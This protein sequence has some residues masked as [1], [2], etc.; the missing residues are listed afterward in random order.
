ME[1]ILPGGVLSVLNHIPDVHIVK[2]SGC[3]CC[4][5]R[6]SEYIDFICGYGPL[7]LG[8]SDPNINTA[9]SKQL[10]Q[11]MLFPSN[12]PLYRKL[13]NVLGELFER[14][15]DAI[16]L[17]T[18]SEAVHAAVR[19]AR[20]HTCK[21]LIVRCGFH[22]WH[23]SFVSP[24]V[25][26]HRYD[27]QLPS[28]TDV[29]GILSTDNN[30][31]TI[32]WDGRDLDYL[33]TLFRNCGSDIA[34]IIID[35]IQIQEPIG[36]NLL[37]IK[38]IAERGKA[39]LILDEIKTGFRV[40]P[41]GVQQAYGI[42]ADITVLSK[43]ISNGFPLS[44]VLANSE[45]MERRKATKIMGTYNGELVSIVAALET[46]SQIN[47]HDVTTWI[48]RMGIQF[49]DGI[50]NVLQKLHL[51]NHVKAVPYRWPCMPYMCFDSS[52]EGYSLKD[53]FFSKLIQK[54]V[55]MLANHPSFI[56]YA[57]KEKHI[58]RAVDVIQQIFEELDSIDNW[59]SPSRKG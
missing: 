50:N 2:A 48:N 7:I 18:G 43:A 58:N 59:V 12:H 41:G 39:L 24:S 32:M 17:K 57:H 4:D 13:K 14:A 26:W 25:P 27:E 19:L 44:V 15:D 8:H 52:P 28:G 20:T 47:Q 30:G 36:K 35:P 45:I 40:S 9:V 29:P 37:Q 3:I 21:Q 5:S 56:S 10:Q 42:A 16:F 51:G 31:G 11:G 22:G 1:E 54:G 55:L 38:E 53:T 49:I 34:A 33:Q 46:I 23:D 6:G